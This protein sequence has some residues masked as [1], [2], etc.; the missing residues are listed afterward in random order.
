MIDS[1]TIWVSNSQTG[2]VGEPSAIAIGG[3]TFN[4]SPDAN[5]NPHALNFNSLNIIGS[6]TTVQF[7]QDTAHGFTWEMIGEVAVDGIPGVPEPGTWSL[8]VLAVPVLA[9]L[10][11]KMPKR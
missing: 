8:T 6:S 10:R 5:T 2:G 4:L 7:F 11:R 3:T 9:L 1:A